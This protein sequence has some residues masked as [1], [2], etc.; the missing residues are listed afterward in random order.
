MKNRTL[1]L[2][3]LTCFGIS[4]LSGCGRTGQE[5][6]SG[7]ESQESKQQQTQQQ[8]IPDE[9][10]ESEDGGQGNGQDSPN[11]AVYMTRDITS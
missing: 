8:T 5:K 6:N 9:N 1:A 2:I 11:P 7:E 10:A 4:S 3:L